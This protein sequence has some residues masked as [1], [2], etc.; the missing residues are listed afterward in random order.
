MLKKEREALLRELIIN[1]YILTQYTSS[2]H[3]RVTKDKERPEVGSTEWRL[4]SCP[5]RVTSRIS[6]PSRVYRA[7]NSRTHRANS[8]NYH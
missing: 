2:K 7:V 5:S 8:S 4:I 6:I 1:K 3:Q